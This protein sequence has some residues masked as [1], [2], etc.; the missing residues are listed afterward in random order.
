MNIAATA[1]EG[2][3][4]VERELK[5]RGVYILERLPGA[6]NP[7]LSNNEAWTRWRYRT[8][9]Q[10]IGEIAVSDAALRRVRNMP[11]IVADKVAAHVVEAL[12]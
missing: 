12:D 8:L 3:A 9:Y 2:Q 10:G 6:G 5:A 7:K 1:I 11:T 4:A